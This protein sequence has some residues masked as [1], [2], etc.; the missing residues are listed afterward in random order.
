M[1]DQTR[2][3]VSWIDVIRVVAIYLV[4]V[5]HVSGQLTN[6]WGKIPTGQWLIADVYGGIARVCVPLFF[7]ISGYLLLPRAESLGTFYTRR[8]PKILIPLVAWSLIYLG[9]YC[10][11]HPGTC[12][13][14]FV[15][16]LLLV[17]GTYYHLWFLYSL[18][19]IYLILPVL[20]LMIRP[21]TD[22]RLLCYLIALWLVFQPLL[23]LAHKFWNFSINLNA[24][25]APG[26]VPYF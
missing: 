1:K 21:D 19:S 25:L 22:T 9:W 3:I 23:S 4:V 16:N 15:W 8:I 26:F 7:M 18:L 17:Q 5:V 20:R 13:P 10:G 24:P 6:L 12:T 14:N 2:E 11:N